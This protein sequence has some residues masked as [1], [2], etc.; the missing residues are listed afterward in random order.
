MAVRR[1]QPARARH[2]QPGAR[3]RSS[4]GARSPD[5]AR[6]PRARIGAAPIADTDRHVDDTVAAGAGDPAPLSIYDDLL[7]PR[8]LQ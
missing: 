2:Y 1:C 8:V 5:A 6:R 4:R 7:A 3:G